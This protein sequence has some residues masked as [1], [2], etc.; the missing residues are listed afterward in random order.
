MA[1]E[2]NLGGAAAFVGAAPT[3]ANGQ[4]YT[5]RSGDSMYLIARQFNI[6]LAT[7]VAA[8]QQIADPNLIYP[9]QSI[10]IPGQAAPTCANGQMYTV[11]S[12]DSMF[13]IAQQFNIPLATLIAANP[14]IANPSLIFPGQSIC[15]PGQVM[16][17]PPPTPMP[18][19]TPVPACPGGFTYTVQSGD[20]LYAIAQKYGI[21]LDALEAANPQITNPD[22][23]FPGQL[24]CVPGVTPPIVCTNG[25]MYTVVS[26]DTMFDI[27]T[28]FGITLQAL[29]S[30]NPQVADPNR[31]F[32]GQVICIPAMVMTP[33]PPAPV[34][35]SP[36]VTPPVTLPAP[37][38][39]IAPPAPVFPIMPITPPA[40]VF[41]IMPV[42]PPAPVSPVTVPPAAPVSPI[43][44]TPLPAP[45]MPPMMPAMPMLPSCPLPMPACPMPCPPMMIEPIYDPCGKKKRCHHKHHHRRRH[46]EC[47]HFEITPF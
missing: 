42:A 46:D 39:P 21:T 23:I 6:P 16:P 29:L 33:V 40:P 27:A 36:A 41:P 1:E 10:C 8:N 9:G 18:L 32:P 14:Q 47:G 34:T 31:I 13:L 26:G 35:I 44:V 45:A 7:L 20:S 28:R 4:L 15:I 37:V 25:T 38:M 43:T 3:C 30:A 24:V 22:L 12:G 11:K 19:P 17:V 2:S 5:V